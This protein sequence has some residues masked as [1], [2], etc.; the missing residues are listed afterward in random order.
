VKVDEIDDT[1]HYID[2]ATIL[3]VGQMRRVWTIQDSK[4]RGLTG[5]MSVLGFN[6]HDC[7][8]DRVRNLS[9]S[10][11]SEPMAGGETL[12]SLDTP[13]K[14][15]HIPPGTVAAAIHE[16]VCA[17]DHAAVGVAKGV[18]YDRPIKL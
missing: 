14:W 17:P 8:G 7:A 11:H 16:I 5:E 13:S 4:K 3:K 2:P 10:L 9:L 12:V 18:A 1:T 6:E 15:A